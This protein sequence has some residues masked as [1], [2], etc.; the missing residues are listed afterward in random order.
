VKSFQIMNHVSME[1]TSILTWLTVQENFLA[2]K[3]LHTGE[4]NGCPHC[5][6]NL[7][8]DYCFY[9]NSNTMFTYVNHLA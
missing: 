4:S 5:N 3:K 6:Q 8:K 9:G 2:N 1:W 7:D